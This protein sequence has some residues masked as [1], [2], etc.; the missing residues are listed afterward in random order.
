[1]K[2]LSEKTLK[3][4]HSNMY[5]AKHQSKEKAF[6]LIELL[7]VIA[8][9]GL[10]S[11]VVLYSV[12]SARER[13]LDTRRIADLRQMENQIAIAIASGIQI[14]VC[15]DTT[16]C[17]NLAMDDGWIE[18][19]N[20]I[21]ADNGS[22]AKTVGD[23]G[24]KVAVYVGV[25]PEDAFADAASSFQQTRSNFVQV[26]NS[27]SFMGTAK[28][29]K[30]VNDPQCSSS[31]PKTCYRLWSDGS[32]IVISTALRTKKHTNSGKNVQYGIVAGKADD[33]ALTTACAGLG[34]P[35]FDSTRNA[36]DSGACVNTN[37]PHSIVSGISNGRF[38]G[39]DSSTGSGGSGGG[40]G[41][42]LGF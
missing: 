20:S 38:I 15:P 32:T 22:D 14:P 19:I 9:I 1:M 23:L 40:S 24:K 2:A 5:R 35:L 8:I 13:A 11:S 12:R 3:K 17:S 36:Y 18:K 28:A 37:G 26:M 42:G 6:T 25:L 41:G 4:I 39:G 16:T 33:A 34:F 27:T 21:V 29:F 10:L 7:V 30:D 31:D